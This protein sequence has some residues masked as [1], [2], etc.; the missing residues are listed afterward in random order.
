MNTYL[1]LKSIINQHNYF[2]NLVDKQTNLPCLIYP[3]RGETEN[4]VLALYLKNDLSE[5][6][7]VKEYKNIDEF[8]VTVTDFNLEDFDTHYNDNPFSSSSN[9]PVYLFDRISTFDKTINSNPTL[10][11]A[12][13]L[14]ENY[15]IV[16]N[17]DWTNSFIRVEKATQ[18]NSIKFDS[19]DH[20]DELNQLEKQIKQDLIDNNNSIIDFC[21]MINLLRNLKTPDV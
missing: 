19:L 20:F 3:L 9:L 1:E 6:D 14:F 12:I 4:K 15:V 18:I 8:S 13:C 16:Y 17:H 10:L 7:F 11:Y 21:I 5:I 2:F